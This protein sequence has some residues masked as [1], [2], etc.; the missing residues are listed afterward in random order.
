[1]GKKLITVFACL[2]FFVQALYAQDVIVKQNGDIINSKVLE[3]G[4]EIV[5]YKKFEHLTGPDYTI[6]AAEVFM[7]KYETNNKD[8]FEKNPVTGKIQIRH[9]KAEVDTGNLPPPAQPQPV[10]QQQPQPQPQPAPP[11]TQVKQTNNGTF[12][13]LGF[14][15]ASV[16]FRA[17]VET[18][19]YMV[20]LS[21]DD[22]SV[23][24][25]SISNNK[26]DI[27]IG[28]GATATSG[29][30]LLLGG[31]APNLRLQKDTE[32]KCTF[33]NIPAGFT[34]TAIVLLTDEKAAP[35]SYNISSGE[36]IKLKQTG[37]AG[38]SPAQSGDDPYSAKSG[39]YD[40]VELLENNIVE[41]EISG[42]DIT[43]VNVKIRRLVPYAVN[44]KI[45]IGSFFVSENPS[46]QNMVAT[47]EKKA[48]L[49]TG[50]WQ[51]VSIPA[52]CANRPKD[53][54]D[55][56]DKFSIR[57][58]PSQE[59][60]VKLMPVLNKANASIPV[61]Q[62]A[63]WIVTDNA[64]FDDLGILTNA[65]NTRA[66]WYESTVRAMKICAEAGIDITKKRIWKDKETI[67]SKL[68]AGELKTWLM[69]FEDE[70]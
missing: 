53:I 15:G 37:A 42:N 16:T 50:G 46:A 62:A 64:N 30:L 59:E 28:G 9:I 57:Q 21:S 48:R 1:M 49:T 51:N 69:N 33:E 2:V 67:V 3:V 39:E 24:A 8:I 45:P 60:L 31:S 61:K 29:S 56:S 43:Q 17:M 54:P 11:S 27:I 4:T 6:S 26:G 14:D 34:P 38:G 19:F 58:S 41:A 55:N 25:S 22:R 32:V 66:I 70:R 52:A 40:I 23:K 20:S 35:M 44:V 63:V 47:D 13:M 7:I 18:P 12:E 5:K 68:S 10:Q 36:W 65:D